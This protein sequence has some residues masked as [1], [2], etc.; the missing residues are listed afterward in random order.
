[1]KLKEEQEPSIFCTTVNPKSYY[2]LTKEKDGLKLTFYS[3]DY[4]KVPASKFNLMDD[5]D[6]NKTY[7]LIDKIS[8]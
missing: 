7:Y 1:M 6:S 5:Y 2:V 8:L 3:K 4:P